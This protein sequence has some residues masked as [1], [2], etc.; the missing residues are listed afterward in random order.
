VTSGCAL[1]RQPLPYPS[2]DELWTDL[3]A[4][5]W[6]FEQ[7]KSVSSDAPD[8]R[9][10]VSNAGLW[11]RSAPEWVQERWADVEALKLGAR[12]RSQANAL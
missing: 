9:S 7:P 8:F 5:P 12:V 10:L 6:L 3:L 4:R 11:R 2:Q 1:L